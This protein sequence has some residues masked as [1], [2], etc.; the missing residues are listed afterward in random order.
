MSSN[1][2]VTPYGPCAHSPARCATTSPRSSPIGADV[3]YRA[4]LTPADEVDAA[5]RR[6]CRRWSTER[7]WV[8]CTQSETLGCNWLAPSRAD[9]YERGRC[10]ARL[11]DPPRT[12]R[13]RHV[14]A[15]EA[16][17]DSGGVA[18]AGLPTRRHRA[19]GRPVLAPR[20]R[21]G[22]RPVVQ[23]QH[24]REGDH[25]PRRTASSRS[26]SSNRLT[27]TASRCGCGSASR[28][29]RCSA[30]S[31]TRSATTTSTCWSRPVLA[32]TRYLDECRALFG[33]ERASYSRRHRAALQVRRTR[34]LGGD[35][36]LGV[37][38]HASVGG[39]RRVLRALPAHRR[40]HRHQP[41]GGHGVARR[42]GAVLRAA[43]HR[44]AG[45]L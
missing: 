44:A 1:C 22:V 38:H 24:R 18:P 37:R 20:R 4:G 42:P 31:A 8:R 25:R 7:R 39:L 5:G 28:T 27:T 35:V 2:T 13:R 23:L 3:S 33:D 41:R 45:V 9:A 30:T 29:A 17:A 36:H 6:R 21:A 12:R 15:R 16:G 19:A 14:G 40:H 10:L 34:R 11:V 26:T 32:Q 43:G